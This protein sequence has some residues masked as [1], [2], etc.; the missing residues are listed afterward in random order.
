M[1]IK[2]TSIIISFL[3]LFVT[4][5]TSTH[6]AVIYTNGVYNESGALEV[7]SAIGADDFVLTSN[8]VV[9]GAQLVIRDLTSNAW[10]RSTINWFLFSSG[11]TP[12]SL[13]N[14]GSASSVSTTSLGSSSFSGKELLDISFD[15]GSS[16]SLL[17]STQYWLGLNFEQGT[18]G[19]QW[20]MSDINPG[21]GS[22]AHTSTNNG[23]SWGASARDMNF[24]LV[25]AVSEPSILA[26]MGLGIFGLGLSRRKM[27]K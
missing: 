15:F 6:A 20:L 22:M 2:K 27:K 8:S 25:N 17:S 5:I 26:L 16:I 14:S 23:A 9:T 12:G 11:S 21:T 4:F 13:L 1:H 19:V 18:T 3:L 10:D 24:K 7:G